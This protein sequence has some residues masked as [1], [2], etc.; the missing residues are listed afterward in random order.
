METDK[1]LLVGQEE[2]EV[3]L[4]RL[5][6]QLIENHEDFSS[7]VI[8]GLQPRGP[9]LANRIVTILRD[10]FKV[11]APK[12][13]Y[14]DITFFRDDFRRRQQPI[15]ANQTKIDFPVEDL[16]VVFVDDVLYTGRSVRA[17]LDAIH[18]FGRPKTIELLCLID[19]RFTRHLP[20]QPNYTGRQVDAIPSERVLVQW[21]EE[22]DS[23]SVFLVTHKE[24][25]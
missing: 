14:L 13:G 5:C 7:T 12:L 11:P 24:N 19:R 21:Q 8:I 18:S 20:I 22:G 25:E 3:V 23:D 16:H 17:A 10:T 2:L 9:M 15:K 1:K 4:N 6:R